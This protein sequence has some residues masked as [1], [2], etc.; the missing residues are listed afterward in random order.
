MRLVHRAEWEDK[1]AQTPFLPDGSLVA[2]DYKAKG[3]LAESACQV[4][5]K[6]LWYSRLARPDLLK[7]TN[8]VTKWLL[9]DDKKL[10]RLMGYVRATPH[11]TLVT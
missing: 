1:P 11:Q 9:A 4:L 2:S 8:D 6:L 3:A 10:F 5:M 7:P